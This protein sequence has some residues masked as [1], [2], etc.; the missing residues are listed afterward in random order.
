MSKCIYINKNDNQNLLK[1]VKDFFKT[2]DIFF[3][4]D[5]LKTNLN[6]GNH[7]CI[8]FYSV[9]NT[10]EGDIVFLGFEDYNIRAADCLKQKKILFIQKQDLT[11]IDAIEKNTDI[12]I[13]NHE[14]IRKTK[15]AEI[16]SIFR[17]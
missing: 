11:A 7:A 5:T 13:H 12:Y 15:N 2:E 4:I 16:Q 6:I 8:N 17:D 3:S 9:I 14:K 10:F 1:R